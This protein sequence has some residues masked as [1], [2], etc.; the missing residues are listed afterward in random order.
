[1]RTVDEARKAALCQL[2]KLLSEPPRL[3]LID[4]ATEEY[5]AGWVFYYQSAA[6]VKSGDAQH[7]LVGNA[8]LFVPREDSPPQFISYHR[9][10]AESLD[11]FRY[12]GDA[13][14]L[15]NAEVE[16][17]TWHEGA[18]AAQAIRAIRDRSSLGVAMAK[19]AVDSCL[20]GK[21][22][23]V[24]TSNVSAAR[25]LQKELETQGFSGRV[26]YGGLK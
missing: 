2:D 9:S 1:M 12:C 24:P 25:A 4:S 8:P 20:S 6:Y 13:N 11:A 17:L 7:A 10:V 22:I 26:T 21:T 15:P 14:A 18:D 23:K 19:A 5:P 3:A 16:L